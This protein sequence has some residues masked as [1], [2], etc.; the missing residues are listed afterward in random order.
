M[1]SIED[2]ATMIDQKIEKYIGVN[3]DATTANKIQLIHRPS[4]R[5]CDYCEYVVKECPKNRWGTTHVAINQLFCKFN[6]IIIDGVT[7]NRHRERNLCGYDRNDMMIPGYV[8]RHNSTR[9]SGC[10]VP[11][12]FVH[13]VGCEYDVCPKCM[14]RFESCVCS[15]IETVYAAENDYIEK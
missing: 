2:Y 3:S 9:C 15:R 11:M 13:H 7:Y 8:N 6:R 4:T 5:G 14:R 12:G 10:G 1:I